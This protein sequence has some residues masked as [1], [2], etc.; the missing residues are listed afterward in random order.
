MPGRCASAAIVHPATRASGDRNAWFSVS[1]ASPSPSA[2]ITT[3]T[4]LTGG[5]FIS[6][7]MLRMAIVTSLRNSTRSSAT[8]SVHARFAFGHGARAS[9]PA[10]APAVPAGANAAAIS[11]VTCGMNGCSRW[12]IP[13]STRHATTRAVRWSTGSA[14][15]AQRGLIISRY[16]SQYSCHVNW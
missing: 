11:S 3:S 10:A 16:Q 7:R 14:P 4:I 15:S 8:G 1:V 2:L 9:E 13:S 5:R 12:R 6:E